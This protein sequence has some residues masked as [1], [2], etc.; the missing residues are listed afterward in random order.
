MSKFV[1]EKNKILFT[2]SMC[3]YGNLRN[4]VMKKMSYTISFME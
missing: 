4:N 3:V 1:K 2:S